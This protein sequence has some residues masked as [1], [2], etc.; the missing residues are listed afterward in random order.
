[1]ATKRSSAAKKKKA[2][3]C[4]DGYSNYF[5]GKHNYKKGKNGDRVRDC[6]SNEEIAA[7]G[8]KGK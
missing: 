5:N 7:M 3:S 8:K 6:K 1:M 4:W 2:S